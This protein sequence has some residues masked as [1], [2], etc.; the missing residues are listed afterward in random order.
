MSCTYGGIC[1]KIAKTRT[2]RITNNKR[3]RKIL[4]KEFINLT[5]HYI[6]IDTVW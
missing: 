4:R 3:K 1:P 2:T 5:P 6:H